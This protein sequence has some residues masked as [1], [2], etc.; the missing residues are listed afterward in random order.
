LPN[1]RQSTLAFLGRA[2]GDVVLRLDLASSLH[3][4]NP[5]NDV[6]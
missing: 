4:D 3:F 5:G 6:L 1:W 2:A